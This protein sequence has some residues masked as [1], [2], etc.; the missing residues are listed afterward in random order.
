MIGADH[1]NRAEGR[2]LCPVMYFKKKKILQA[3]QTSIL[4]YRMR[5]SANGM[6]KSSQTEGWATANER[7]TCP[8]ETYQQFNKDCLMEMTALPEEP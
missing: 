2:D 8:Q 1:K 7:L 5:Y 4:Q 6:S 3:R